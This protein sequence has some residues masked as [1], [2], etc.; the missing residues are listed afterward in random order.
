MNHRSAPA[1]ALLAGIALAAGVLP[2]PAPAQTAAP[3]AGQAAT[4]NAEWIWLPAAP[5]A[6]QPA[7][8]VRH[9]TLPATPERARLVAT[10]DNRMTLYV[11][12]VQVASSDT[13]ESPVR[14]DI[15]AHLRPGLNAL[16]VA[17]ENDGGPAGLALHLELVHADGAREHIVTSEAWRASQTPVEGWNEPGFALRLWGRAASIGSTADASLPWGAVMTIRHATPASAITLPPGFTAELVHSAQP[18]EGSWVSLVLDAQGRAIVSPETGGLLR[19][20][21]TGPETAEVERLGVDI[22]MCQGLLIAHGALYATVTENAERDGGLHRLRDE[23][24]DGAFETHEVLARFPMRSEHGPHGLVLGPDGMIY[25]V[26]GNYTPLPEGL[27]VENSPYRDWAE[28]TLVPRL[29]DP[30]GHAVNLMMPAGRVL[31]TDPDGERWELVAGGLRN[32]YDL[33]FAPNGELFTYDS[34]MEWDIGLPWYRPPRIVHVVEGADYGWRSG[35]AKFPDWYPDTL[36]PVLETDLSSPVG[37]AFPPPGALPEPWASCL[38]AGDWAYG[39]ILAV[40]LTPDGATWSGASESFASALPLSVTD[41]AFAADGAMWFTTGGR[42]TQSG[43]YR[44]TYQGDAPPA[45]R[46]DIATLTDEMTLRRQL[47]SPAPGSAAP[48]I[49]A[50]IAHEDR[51]VRHAARLAAQRTGNHLQAFAG[52]E[53]AGNLAGAE[54]ALLLARDAGARASPD[55]AI[56]AALQLLG[57]SRDADAHAAALR[58]IALAIARAG[59]PSDAVRQRLLDQYNP[60][61]PSGEPRLHAILAELL[62]GLESPDIAHRLLEV[63]E[64]ARTR[65]DSIHAALCLRLVAD[66]LDDEQLARYFTWLDRARTGSGGMS[67]EGYIRAIE[68][69]ALAQLDPARREPIEA[70]LAEL[71]QAE[72]PPPPARPFVRQWTL[73]AALD[74]VEGAGGRRSL[75]R[76]RD[77]YT[78]ARCA[79]CHRFDGAGGATG[80]DLTGVARRFSTRDLLEAI[81]DP[82]A[83]VSDQYRASVVTLHD[84]RVLN[85]RLLQ[86]TGGRMDVLTDPY[87][88]DVVSISPSDIVSIEASPVSPMPPG[89]LD[90][91]TPAEVADLVAYLRSGAAP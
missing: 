47:A 24:G 49:A 61:Y 83:V 43:L 75:D 68:R 40:H 5:A 20:T 38:F 6:N 3:K 79:E 65:E 88:H 8:F 19:L 33:A 9:F 87:S 78:A 50:A 64:R 28:D 15:A 84:G 74:A 82:S 91:L 59:P 4:A 63:V 35:S 53:R 48:D 45:Q 16:A 76:G 41:I 51:F 23:N 80:P 22:G 36:P 12:G 37:V 42:G 62:T 26:H 2:P 69:D 58:V 52:A 81:V 11:N 66:Q 30:R 71:D 73:P 46:P 90:T 44:I 25:T 54:A 29:W 27:D 17:C 31:R 10:C 77:L 70:L 18:G 72:A 89:L 7:H 14:L 1:A 60:L 21:R 55:A 57:P 32:A 86:I 34:D 56:N 13:W 85:G 67:F 39:R